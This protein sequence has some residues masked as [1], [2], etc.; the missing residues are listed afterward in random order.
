MRM[1]HTQT[2]QPMNPCSF[3]RLLIPLALFLF[4]G[5]AARAVD[6]T[7]LDPTGSI[8][9]ANYPVSGGYSAFG[10][11]DAGLV[12][13]TN[14]YF[15]ILW[16]GGS[17]LGMRVVDAVNGV[18]YSQAGGIANSAGGNAIVGAYSDN[19]YG[20]HGFALTGWSP[21]GFDPGL[22]LTG[23][24][25]T[26][27]LLDVP[28]A[29]YTAALG[30]NDS[31]IIVGNTLDPAT[32]GSGGFVFDGSSYN[33]FRIA[34]ANQ[35]EASDVNNANVVVGTYLSN[36][37]Y[38]GYVASLAG[39]SGH[40]IAAFTTID[41]PAPGTLGTHLTGIND[42]GDLTGWYQDADGRE[43]GL[44]IGGYT[45]LD[46]VGI[47]PANFL[48]RD[49]RAYGVNAADEV[50]GQSVENVNFA[51]VIGSHAFLATGFPAVPEPGTLSLVMLMLPV[52][53]G[54]R[55]PRSR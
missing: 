10:I 23:I 46:Y 48:F 54:G 31:Q 14:N 5:R 1:L 44:F 43:H 33:I 2:T 29:P 32:G 27:T 45:I 17:M 26:L 12:V 19:N 36:T 50:V 38:H 39:I 52:A 13:G 7:Q 21:S 16:S 3:A 35:T 4:C 53:L 8:G 25:G 20:V 47:N 51:G 18:R 42:A 22:G 34:G 15:G 40:Q 28:G 11:N 49:T 41:A 6:Y 9:D 55:R 37:G 24:T 30:I